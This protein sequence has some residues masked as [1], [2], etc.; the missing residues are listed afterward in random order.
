MNKEKNLKIEFAKDFALLKTKKDF[1]QALQRVECKATSENL[2]TDELD[3]SL[4]DLKYEW[5][6]DEKFMQKIFSSKSFYNPECFEQLPKSI[7]YGGKY[8]RFLERIIL[9]NLE[10]Y[11]A[12]FRF[13][14]KKSFSLVS[15]SNFDLLSF[16]LI[17]VVEFFLI[18]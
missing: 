17:S 11:P 12:F 8:K 14:T 7:I 5:L 2:L 13:L 18:L 6:F 3:L 16:S 4:A 9:A 10:D 15:T 1:E